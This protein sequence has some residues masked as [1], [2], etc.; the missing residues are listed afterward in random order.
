M[1]LALFCH[2]PALG[3]VGKDMDAWVGL[4]FLKQ[5]LLSKRYHEDRVSLLVFGGV[6]LPMAAVLAVLVS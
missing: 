4:E 1:W 6:P 5:S 2:P 3:K